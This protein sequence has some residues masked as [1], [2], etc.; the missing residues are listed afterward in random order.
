M[1]PPKVKEA[2]CWQEEFAADELGCRVVE[3]DH[4]T[5]ALLIYL[6]VFFLGLTYASEKTYAIFCLQDKE[7][8]AYH[9]FAGPFEK[10]VRVL[11]WNL[12]TILFLSVWSLM[13]PRQRCFI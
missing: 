1:G 7:R 5:G 3:L 6:S 13:P 10:S 8:S 12:H 4:S 2:L 11:N 9:Y